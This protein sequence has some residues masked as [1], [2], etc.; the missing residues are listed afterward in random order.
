MGP[1]VAQLALSFGANDLGS[2]MLEENVVAA[3]GVSFRLGEAELR[4]L[5]E[6]AGFVP[7]RRRMDYTLLEDA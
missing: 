3:A 2:T 1:K 4:R 7:R 6:A 5:A